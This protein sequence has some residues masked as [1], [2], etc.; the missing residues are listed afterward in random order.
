MTDSDPTTDDLAATG[1][2]LDDDGTAW[3]VACRAFA[4]YVINHGYHPTDTVVL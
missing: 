2:Q 4:S 1:A 3:T